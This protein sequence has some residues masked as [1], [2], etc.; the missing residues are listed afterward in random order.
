MALA[1]APGLDDFGR[2]IR[3]CDGAGLPVD[4]AVQG[5][6]RHL[7]PGLELSVYRVVQESLTNSLSTPGRPGVR[8]VHYRPDALE[9]EVLDDG[10]GAAS[11]VATGGQGWWGCASGSR[12]TAG[13][14][15]RVEVRRRLPG[16][17]R[18]PD[19]GSP[20]TT[21]IRVVV[22]DDQALMRTGFG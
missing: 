16:P 20:M 9:V 5:E 7:A 18:L 21:P 3:H 2:L 19:H 11:T 8:D 4:F 14:C 12:P 22:V 6:P 13:R 15:R 1:P 17:R 10:R